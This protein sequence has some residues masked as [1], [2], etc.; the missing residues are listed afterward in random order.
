MSGPG[1][2]AGSA[3]YVRCGSQGGGTPYGGKVVSRTALRLHVFAI[4][5]SIE[6]GSPGVVSDSYLDA[7]TV[8][9]SSAAIELCTAGLWERGEGGYS[10]A[11]GE[12]YR[13]A[14][15]VHRQLEDLSAQCRADGGHVPDPA[16]PALCRNCAV[17]LS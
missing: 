11:E 16:D 12:T 4:L 3:A 7:I 5:A 14:S 15:E 17:R 6:S 9:T 1:E 13:V 8:D 2:D 10:V